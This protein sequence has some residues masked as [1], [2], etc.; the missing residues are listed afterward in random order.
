MDLP[1]SFVVKCAV[2]P[3][4]WLFPVVEQPYLN[5]RSSTCDLSPVVCDEG[6][7]RWVHCQYI[8]ALNLG[9]NNIVTLTLTLTDLCAFIT[10]RW[11]S[12]LGS[13]RS[14]VLVG[15]RRL[16]SVAVGYP[17]RPS[18]MGPTMKY[19]CWWGAVRSFWNEIRVRFG[20]FRDTTLIFIFLL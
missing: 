20:R 1:F 4:P 12:R 13:F 14:V 6:Q 7:V 8:L 10:C 2:D 11:R 19:T 3:A 5:G 15:W 17:L 16:N 18:D 9:G